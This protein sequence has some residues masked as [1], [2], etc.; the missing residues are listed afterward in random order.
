M[1]GVQVQPALPRPLVAIIRK[2]EGTR[3]PCPP[4]HWSWTHNRRADFGWGPMDLKGGRISL[5]SWHFLSG[6]ICFQAIRLGV[7]RVEWPD[8]IPELPNSPWAKGQYPVHFSQPFAA[9]NTIGRRAKRGVSWPR[10]HGR[11]TACG[12]HS[13]RTGCRPESRPRWRSGQGPLRRCSTRT[14][15]NWRARQS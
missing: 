11:T 7:G 12:A 14:V 1:G 3:W 4:R 6:A 2:P 8:F 5:G 9:L 15:R 10:S 13:S